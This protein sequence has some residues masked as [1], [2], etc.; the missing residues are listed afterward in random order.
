M[1]CAEGRFTRRLEHSTVGA[2]PLGSAATLT[3]FGG[4]LSALAFRELYG[5]TMHCLI[6]I[7]WLSRNRHTQSR[8][9]RSE[10]CVHLSFPP[11]CWGKKR[12]HSCPWLF[13][14]INSRHHKDISTEQH[15]HGTLLFFPRLPAR[16]NKN[17]YEIASY[18]KHERMSGLGL[19]SKEQLN[20]LW[21]GDSGEST[22]LTG[23][24]GVGIYR[25]CWGQSCLEEVPPS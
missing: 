11:C 25:G 12:A 16:Y 24:G 21:H 9:E 22:V 1:S 20:R 10:L 13:C 17:K 5:A 23:S 15:H 18:S 8:T 7:K 19:I 3:L 2:I 4:C 14:Q 6:S